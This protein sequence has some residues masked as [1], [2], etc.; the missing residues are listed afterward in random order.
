[1]MKKWANRGILF[2]FFTF[3]T[4]YSQ[5]ISFFLS[6]HFMC[7][8]VGKSISHT[9]THTSRR[10][11]SSSEQQERQIYTEGR[12]RVCVDYWLAKNPPKKAERGG[13]VP[14]RGT[15]INDKRYPSTAA[16]A[17]GP[18]RSPSSPRTRGGGGRR[19]WRDDGEEGGGE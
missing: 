14:R 9:Y 18:S 1:M 15:V 16:I 8:Y 19:I 11:R 5:Q 6:L 10:Y 12:A 2:S 7:V 13:G 4:C 17:S 3:E